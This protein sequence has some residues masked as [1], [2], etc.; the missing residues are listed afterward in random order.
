M[1]IRIESLQNR[2]GK[3]FKHVQFSCQ[4]KDVH[5][6]VSARRDKTVYTYAKKNDFSLWSSE[7]EKLKLSI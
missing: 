5:F 6:I 4:V 1:E 2:W 7:Y 3:A